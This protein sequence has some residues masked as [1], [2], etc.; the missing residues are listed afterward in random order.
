MPRDDG[1]GVKN[2]PKNMTSLMDGLVYNDHQQSLGTNISICRCALN[3]TGKD[4]VQFMILYNIC[5][6]PRQKYALVGNVNLMLIY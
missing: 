6:L 4:K 5:D 3:A 1:G 2:R